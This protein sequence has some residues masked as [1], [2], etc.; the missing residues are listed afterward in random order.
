MRVLVSG[1]SGLVGS[2]L[3]AALE[4]A[5]HAVRRLVRGRP[6]EGDVWW[7]PAGGA[8]QH[9]GLEGLDAVVHL[10]GVGIAER[11]WTEDQKTRIRD[12][13]VVGTAL[14]ARSL[15]GLASP[16]RVLLSAS[17]VGFYGDRGDETLTEESSAGLGFLAAVC[18]EWEAAT[19]PAEAAGIRVVHLRSGIVQSGRGGSLRQVLPLF[20]AGLGGRLSTGRQ[21]LSW[22]SVEDEVGAICH[23]IEAEAARGPLNL[24][25]PH[26]VT[27]VEY[28]KTLA[29]VLGRPAALP[30]PKAALSLVLGRELTRELVLVSQRVLPARLKA[31]GYTFRH[32][33]L[34]PALRA[35]LGR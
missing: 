14:L 35:L 31:L 32:P 6:R 30:V 19:A 33:R 28:T 34:E 5:G 25:S 8:I 26:P 22:V 29:R 9:H 20:K 24:T 3:V 23:A 11:R 27:N 16:P 4:G 1:S 13:R 2:A 7:D 12:S 10:A 17:A 21:Y 15:A 18:G